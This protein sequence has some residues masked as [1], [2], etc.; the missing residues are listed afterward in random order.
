LYIS[1]FSSFPN[2]TTTN[3]INNLSFY[4]GIETYLLNKKNQ[5]QKTLSS[6]IIF[7]EAEA[8]IRTERV[9]GFTE[10]DVDEKAEISRAFVRRFYNLNSNILQSG[11]NCFSSTS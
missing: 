8:N 3:Q 5:N 10:S 7:L 4:V 6:K 11:L 2:N 1:Y 9:G